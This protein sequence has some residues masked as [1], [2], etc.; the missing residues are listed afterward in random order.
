MRRVLALALLAV[1]A[2]G[3]SAAAGST[4]DASAAEGPGVPAACFGLAQPD[5]TLAYEAAAQDLAPGDQVVYAEVGPFSCPNEAGCPNTLAGR[6]SGQV[7]F[8]RLNGE[9]VAISLTAG[10]DGTITTSPG[11][12]FTVAVSPTSLAG[13]L[14]GEP[15]PYTLGHCGVNSGIDV[16][17]SW[18]DPI[19]FVD[20]DHGDAINAADG[21]FAPHDANHA[22]FTSDG[23]FSVTVVRRVGDKHL[24]M[25]M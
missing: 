24:P 23:G 7:V 1:V 13:Q 11:E 18:W 20:I 12:A 25:C 5:C 17:G 6:P 10:A 4:P 2:A 8:E 3:C 21:T 9:P 19:G 14:V 15:I 16:D 22:T